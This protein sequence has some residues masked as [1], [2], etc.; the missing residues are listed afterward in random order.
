MFLNPKN[1]SKASVLVLVAG[2]TVGCASTSDLEKVRGEA[3]QAQ[4]TANDAKATADAALQAANDASTCCLENRE[5]I[6]R[7]FKRGMMK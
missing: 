7:A 1:L 3:Q 5:A 2:L 6:N 4:A